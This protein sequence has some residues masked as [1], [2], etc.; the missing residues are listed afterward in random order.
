MTRFPRYRATTLAGLM[1]LGVLAGCSGSE[2]ENQPPEATETS[3]VND[4]AAPPAEAP[5][6]TTTIA[7]EPAGLQ[8]PVVVPEIE[9]VEP[10]PPDAQVLEDADA[11]GMT[12]RVRRDEA[13]APGSEETPAASEPA[14]DTGETP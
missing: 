1:A 2:P 8:P 6:A 10:T 12:A 4:D 7:A 5:A 13:P 11:T 14:P 9:P 3:T